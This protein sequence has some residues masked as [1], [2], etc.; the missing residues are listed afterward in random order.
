MSCVL[1]FIETRQNH[2]GS[3]CFH[4]PTEPPQAVF[5]LGLWGS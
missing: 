1:A 5:D 2:K 4:A 3:T